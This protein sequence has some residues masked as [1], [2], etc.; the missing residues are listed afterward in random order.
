VTFHLL[1][2]F[3]FAVAA[4]IFSCHFF[5]FFFF[6]AVFVVFARDLQLS[7][8]K[9]PSFG[10]SN[11]PNHAQVVAVQLQEM[12]VGSPL[13]VRSVISGFVGRYSIIYT[14]TFHIF[15]QNQMQTPTPEKHL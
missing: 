12:A 14:Q 1:L 4:V 10:L 7:L 8:R 6:L 3:A 5:F 15:S 11:I 13:F 9:H 2:I